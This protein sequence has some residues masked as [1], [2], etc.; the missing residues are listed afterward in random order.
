MTVFAMPAE[1]VLV[2]STV[3]PVGISCE[4]FVDGLSV[5]CGWKTEDK[6]VE[7]VSVELGSKASFADDTELDKEDKGNELEL[8]STKGLE[9]KV[10]DNW[11]RMDGRE[12]DT[13]LG[14]GDV[15]NGLRVT[16]TVLIGISVVV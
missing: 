11:E 16:V 7:V 2:I 3:D 9:F 4:I 13:E 1:I 10:T 6:P 12:F 8:E 14:F 15:E 5:D